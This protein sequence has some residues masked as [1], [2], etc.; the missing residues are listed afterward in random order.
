MTFRFSRILFAALMVAGLAAV[1]A[2]CGDDDD[3]DGGSTPT[4]TLTPT[5]HGTETT[6]TPAPSTA[7]PTPPAPA[8]T[9]TPTPEANTSAGFRAALAQFNKE[10]NA[11][12]V[13]PR[14]ARFKV[15]DYTCR[16]IDVAG[17]IGAV[18]GCKAVGEVIRGVATST[19]RSEGNFTS[20]EKIVE[21][22]K[23]YQAALDTARADE[24]GPGAFRGFAIDATKHTAVITVI[25]KCLPQYKCPDTGFQR[26]VWV[27]QFEFIDGR[28]KIASLMYAFVLG[29]EFFTAGGEGSKI[30]LP[31][32]EKF[33]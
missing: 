16:E 3:D 14:I 21:N 25:S 4:T 31:N 29:E 28:W 12:T 23:S 32:W 20:V 6:P 13:D 18:T 22:L 8:G 27:P 26:L 17:G 2:A 19:W 11:G 1:A 24:F 33:Q 5:P 10:I 15:A 7:T 9:L 30:Y